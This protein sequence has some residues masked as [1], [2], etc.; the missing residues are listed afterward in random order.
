VFDDDDDDDDDDEEDQPETMTVVV[1]K[2]Q[3]C[4]NGRK[5]LRPLT[6]CDKKKNEDMAADRSFDQW[7]RDECRIEKLK[8]GG[9]QVGHGEGMVHGQ[10]PT[11]ERSIQQVNDTRPRI[12]K[13]MG[14]CP[15]V[16]VRTA[17]GKVADG[18]VEDAP[19]ASHSAEVQH[20]QAN[21]TSRNN[22]CNI[23]GS[24]GTISDVMMESGKGDN[25]VDAGTVLDAV[26]D[27]VDGDQ[28]NIGVGAWEISDAVFESRG[29]DNGGSGGMSKEVVEEV[30]EES[31][32]TAI[33]DHWKETG[34]TPLA[35][36]SIADRKRAKRERDRVRRE[37]A[38]QAAVD[39][40]VVTDKAKHGYEHFHQLPTGTSTIQQIEN[41]SCGV[42]GWAKYAERA[43]TGIRC[44]GAGKEGAERTLPNPAPHNSCSQSA[45]SSM[46]PSATD[47]S[48]HTHA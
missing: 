10:G 1:G 3:R 40:E 2:V 18:H 12:G 17:V 20:E 45:V 19:M 48:V 43:N 4:K 33:L 11:A 41:T 16:V 6:Q 8:C 37:L 29:G 25:G 5:S 9:V 46:F 24:A 47:E 32:D 34:Q 28:Y 13:E 21:K 7:L 38:H 35:R 44:S 31:N 14:S 23:G 30:G 27:M 39:Y 42:L 26:V 15:Q 22:V 36:M